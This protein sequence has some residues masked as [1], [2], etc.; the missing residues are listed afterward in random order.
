MRMDV[1]IEVETKELKMYRKQGPALF[2]VQL[3]V[4]NWSNGQFHN[5]SRASSGKKKKNLC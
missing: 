5:G 2:G 4:V 3:F 1:N